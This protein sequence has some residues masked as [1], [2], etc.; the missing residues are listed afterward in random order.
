MGNSVVKPF[1]GIGLAFILVISVL[2]L[3][4]A[5]KF[6]DEILLQQEP[7]LLI[8]NAYGDSVGDA[9]ISFI[10]THF[11][12]CIVVGTDIHGTVVFTFTIDIEREATAAGASDI[13]VIVTWLPHVAAGTHQTAAFM[14]LADSVEMPLLTSDPE[15]TIVVS[16]SIPS[17]DTAL[18]HEG[19]FTIFFRDDVGNIISKKIVFAS[20]PDI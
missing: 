9:F 2:S 11:A 8:G 15:E 18:G 19:S 6:S 13:D 1:V 7:T 5:E 12:N 16:F 3:I 10:M 20:C 17:H 14:L 4:P